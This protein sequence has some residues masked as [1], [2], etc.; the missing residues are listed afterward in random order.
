MGLPKG[1][2]NNPRGRPKGSKNKSTSQI[3]NLIQDFVSDNLDDLQKQYDNLDPKD[4]LQFFERILKFVLP[5]QRDVQQT[6]NIKE[7]SDKEMD[8]LIEKITKPE[9]NENR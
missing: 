8:L 2:T 7:L 5:Q 4:K 3:K 6:I 1:K 9:K